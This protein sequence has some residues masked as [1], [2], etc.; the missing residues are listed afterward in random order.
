MKKPPTP[1][2]RQVSLWHQIRTLRIQAAERDGL[3]G[4]GQCAV[5]E[6]GADGHRARADDLCWGGERR[7]RE[8]R[9]HALRQQQAPATKL[10]R[11]FC[12]LVGLSD[13]S[14]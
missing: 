7:R 2:V 4:C 10:V 8:A 1:S 9:D 14:M 6:G 12:I 5:L 11:R 13:F 3:E